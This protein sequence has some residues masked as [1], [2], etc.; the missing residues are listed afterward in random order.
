LNTALVHKNASKWN[1]IM[2]NREIEGMGFISGHWPLD[3]DKPTLVFIPGA[4]L[5][6]IFWEP[7]INYL[8]DV[9]NTVA[10]DLP[11]HGASQGPGKENI[12]ERNE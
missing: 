5:T 11:R 12:S 4:S 10:V 7:Q 2:Q 6:S 9:A 8:K 3:I 1:S